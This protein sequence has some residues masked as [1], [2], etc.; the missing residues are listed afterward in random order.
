LILSFFISSVSFSQGNQSSFG[1]LKEIKIVGN[2]KIEKDAILNKVKLK[3]GAEIK[4]SEVSDCIKEIHKLGYFDDISFLVDQGVLTIEVKERPTITKI[5]FEG[6]EQVSESDLKDVIKLKEYAI[7]DVNKAKED[8][9]AIQKHYEDKGYYLARVSYEVKKTDKPD[10]VHLVYKV[11]DYEKVRIKKITFINNKRFSD[12][13]LKSLM[14]NT[15]EGN[16]FSWISSSGNFKESAF[17]QDLQM[18]TYFYLDN[19]YVKFHY[20]TPIV[21]VSEDKKW[22]FISIFVDEGEQYRVGKV[23]FA[24]DLLFSEEELFNSVKLREGQVFSISKRNEDIQKLTE[25]YQDLGYAFVNVNPRMNINDEE[26]IVDIKYEFEKGNLAYFGE[27]NII[28]NTKTRDKVIRREMRIREGE[29]YNG[30]R[31][32]VS[33]ERIERLGYFAPGEVVINTITRKDNKNIVDVEVSIKERSTGTIT[34]GMGYGSVQKFFLTAQIS[35]IN[36]FGKGQSL[37]FGAQYSS[38]RYSRSFNISFTE[39]Y[40]FDTRW[41]SGVDLYYVVFPIPGRYLQFRKGFN[42]RAGHPIFNDVT[43][44]YSTYKFERLDLDFVRTDIDPDLDVTPDLGYLSSVTV[45][46]VRDV[47]N[48]RFETTQGNYQSVSS[49]FAGTGVGGNKDFIKNIG[50]VR[51]YTPLTDNLVFRSKFEVGHIFQ[52]TKRVIP[53][54]ERFYL[55]GPNNL[56]SF[57]MFSVSP[58]S[59]RGTP[60]G[61]TTEFVAISEFEY[62]LIREA[63]LKWVM[64]LEA[65]NSY[66]SWNEFSSFSEIK[67]GTGFGFRWF[68]PIGPL[69]FEWGFPINR[70]P[71]ESD[72]V[73]NFFIGP[74]F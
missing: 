30:T 27:I 20:E 28:G 69:R 50:E 63:G 72:V 52:T 44:L 66:A 12:D 60:L 31:L 64:F 13:K 5:E 1:V 33:K 54:S 74:P 34:L 8:V 47:R 71:D 68:S 48:N 59:A 18:L 25:K 17:K 49:E 14:R 61:G 19:G 55:G 10:E 38:N 6:N 70:R 11:S 22:L 51:Y 2:K 67:K 39:P 9:L 26:K 15:Q 7:L 53:P 43:M 4:R 29:L 37:S 58:R 3:I 16:F 62:P 36:L 23:D 41:S 57:D 35:E 73:F 45:S 42:L 21:T 32:R 24:G 46:M 40:T 56:K 65:G